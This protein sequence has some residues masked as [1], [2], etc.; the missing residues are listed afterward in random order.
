MVERVARAI[1]P[2]DPDRIEKAQSFDT[3]RH[4]GV[5]GRSSAQVPKIVEFPAWK[6]Y[7]SQ[8]RAA[9]AAMREPTIQMIGAAQ[10]APPSFDLVKDIYQAMI[11]AALKEPEN[12][13][14]TIVLATAAWNAKT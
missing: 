10:S 13:P 5:P 11:N 7:E 3:I 14:A 12:K 6:A 1:C 9:V 4:F 2:G 8:A